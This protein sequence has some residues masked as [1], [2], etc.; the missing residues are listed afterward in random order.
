MKFAD[1]SPFT[2]RFFVLVDPKLDGIESAQCFDRASDA[3][4]YASDYPNSV[5]FAN[6]ALDRGTVKFAD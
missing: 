4:E 3:L 5:I 1:I 6:I 2:N